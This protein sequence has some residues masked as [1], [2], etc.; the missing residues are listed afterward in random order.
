MSSLLDDGVLR[1][2]RRRPHWAS[3]GFNRGDDEFGIGP[4]HSTPVGGERVFARF[5]RE[6][7]RGIGRAATRWVAA[8]LVMAGIARKVR[9]LRRLGVGG[10]GIDCLEVLSWA[11]RR[12]CEIHGLEIS[13]EGSLPTEPCVIVSNHVSYLDPLVVLSLTPARPIAKAAV[14]WWPLIGRL[15]CELGVT[16]VNRR[17]MQQ[18]ARVLRRAIR[19]L[20]EG[21]AVLNFPE[22]TTSTGEE[23]LPLHRG[24]FGAARIAAVPIVPVWLEYSPRWLAWVGNRAFL[25]HYLRFSRLGRS[26]VTVRFGT[27]IL[28]SSELSAR[29]LSMQVAER[30][31]AL[32]TGG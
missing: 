29:A 17:S 31:R 4:A 13:V 30:M 12:T 28:A 18:R 7:G 27:P 1:A 15:A 24:I 2:P 3:A 25:G 6:I 22:G 9:R 10:R 5:V 21:M 16:F 19:T 14:A 23:L 20:R 26:S 32:R 8:F 11:S